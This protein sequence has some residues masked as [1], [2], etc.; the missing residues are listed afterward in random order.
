M[1]GVILAGGTGS[2]LRPITHTGPKQLVPIA[3]KPV[4]EYA[5]D[6][7]VEAGIGEIGIIL[8]NKGRAAIQEYFGDGSDWGVDITYIVQGEPLGL[9]HAVGCAK[10]FVGDDSFVVYLG[11]DL[12]REGITELVEDFN[13]EEYAAGIGLQEVD[14]PSRY[15]I[16]DVNDAG[17]V[18]QL[19]EKPDD[20]PNNLAL[21]GIY[22][23]TP[24]IFEQIEALDKSWR[25]EYEITEAIQ[26][27]LEDGKRIQSH[28]VH[29][30]WKD[31]GKPEDVLHANRLVLDDITPRIDGTIEDEVSVTGRV[32]LGHGSVI[33]EG[34]VVRGPVSIGENTRVTSDTY[35]GPYSSIGDDCVIDSAHIES[36]VVVG[37]SEVSADR[38]IVDS[39]IGRK[40]TITTNHEKK[41]D[42]ERLVVGQNSLLEL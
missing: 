30:W 6:D 26:G 3:N 42:G 39:L 37:E 12:M 32:E 21:I 1:K 10:D 38:T 17:D 41:P 25:G 13:T 34:A 35:L 28:V 16:V 11:D 40:A 36:S 31:T 20:P 5:V 14:E 4:L 9:A 19:V 23:F 15:G 22:V 8:G 29:G 18:I 24:A 27:L 2:R 7:L 33:E